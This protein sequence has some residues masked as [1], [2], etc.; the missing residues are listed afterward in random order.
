MDCVDHPLPAVSSTVQ[1]YRHQ[2]IQPMSCRFREWHLIELRYRVLTDAKRR[3]LQL[4][5]QKSHT[6]V[7]FYQDAVSDKLYHINVSDYFLIAF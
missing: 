5:D 4:F 6:I 2:S 3:Q 1:C 7:D